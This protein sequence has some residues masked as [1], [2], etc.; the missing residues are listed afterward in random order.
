MSRE[1]F[2][3]RCGFPGKTRGWDSRASFCLVELLTRETLFLA[4]G[5]NQKVEVSVGEES[6]PWVNRAARF[7]T[8]HQLKPAVRF[9]LSGGSTFP[10][11]R[12]VGGFAMA[13]QLT[14]AFWRSFVLSR[15]RTCLDAV[16]VTSC[17][18]SCFHG[19]DVDAQ[20]PWH[21]LLST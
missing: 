4:L 11:T 2:G 16:V 3:E 19:P 17:N 5:V 9:V 12:N 8:T 18:Q 20:L 6:W 15:I 14:L 1:R 21:T 7:A 13:M 10:W